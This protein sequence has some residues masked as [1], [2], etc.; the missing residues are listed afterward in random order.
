MKIKFIYGDTNIES[1]DFT[2]A[3]L[4][5]YYEESF[6]KYNRRFTGQISVLNSIN[7]CNFLNLNSANLIT[8]EFY[9]KDGVKLDDL[10]N[11]KLYTINKD[12]IN[13]NCRI[14]IRQQEV[15]GVTVVTAAVEI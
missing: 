4:D 9:N 1:S 5:I 15:K 12:I 6:K 10:I 11:G 14:D 8:I 3:N 2:Q 7:V 13:D